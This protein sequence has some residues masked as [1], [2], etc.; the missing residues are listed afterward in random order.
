MA[1]DLPYLP[2]YKN[3]GTLFERISKAKVP[4]ALTVRVLGD[5][6]GLKVPAIVS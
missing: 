5:T 3:V 4:D 1:K 6:I 2:S